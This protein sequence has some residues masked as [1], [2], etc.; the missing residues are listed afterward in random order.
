M[1]GRGADRQLLERGLELEQRAGAEAAKSTIPLICL[2]STDDREAARSRYR[3]EE[4]WYRERGEEGWLA[5][6]RAHLAWLE[7]RAGRWD[8]ADDM[9]EESCS[10]LGQTGRRGA[11]GVPFGVRALVDAHRGRF[12]RSRETVSS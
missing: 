2:Q 8:L 5:E 4:A 7:F 11:W 9:I 3:I 12:E 10:I 6:R 1:R